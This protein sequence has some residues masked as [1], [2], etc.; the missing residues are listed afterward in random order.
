MFSVVKHNIYGIHI[1]WCTRNIMIIFVHPL[2]VFYLSY[3][4]F[5]MTFISIFSS[6]RTHN[7]GRDGNNFPKSCLLLSIPK[8]RRLKITFRRKRSLKTFSVLSLLFRCENC[9]YRN[10]Y[11]FFCLASLLQRIHGCAST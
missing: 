2:A 9:A 10:L 11:Y 6:N 4:R 3:M 5:A 1:G 8:C 7:I